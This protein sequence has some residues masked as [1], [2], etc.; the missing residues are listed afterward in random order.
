MCKSFVR[1]VCAS[2][3]FINWRVASFNAYFISDDSMSTLAGMPKAAGV[4]Q[5][6]LRYLA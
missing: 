1:G 6:R 4:K 5:Y 2:L 3:I